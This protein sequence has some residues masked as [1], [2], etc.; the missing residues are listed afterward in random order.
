M[1]DK[2]KISLRGNLK[3]LS[4]NQEILFDEHNQIESSALEIITRC[5]SQVDYIKSLDKI[6]AIGNFGK[7]D[8][9]I[10]FVEY[11]P[12]YNS[13]LFRAIFYE[14]DFNGQVDKM[15]LVC[16]TFNK[17]FASKNNLSIS[18]DDQSRIQVDWTIF[19]TS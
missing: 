16:S 17:V 3:I 19:V 5:L 2:L 9:E 13:M 11:N 14:F 4:S 1:N 7:V 12:I 10:T 18:K 15:E 8:R 6:T